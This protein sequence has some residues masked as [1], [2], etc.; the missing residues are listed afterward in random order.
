MGGRVEAVVWAVERVGDGG[1]QHVVQVHLR[2]LEKKT[3]HR[4]AN[5]QLYATTAILPSEIPSEDEPA[6]DYPPPS[7]IRQNLTDT[8]GAD[9]RKS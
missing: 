9:N 7:I 4:S 8:Y 6:P 5:F 1:T 3:K 2:H